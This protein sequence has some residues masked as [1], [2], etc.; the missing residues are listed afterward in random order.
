MPHCRCGR[1]HR[2]SS[3]GEILFLRAKGLRW[4]C[5]AF[6]VF[7]HENTAGR[8]R[9]GVIVGKAN[10]NAVHRNRTKRILREVV[11]RNKSIN[12]PFFDILIK[13]FHKVL[14]SPEEL[15]SSYLRWKH[16]ARG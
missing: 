14:P 16:S 12:P 7:F 6:A 5:N 4:Q 15:R 8:D 11:R 1:E 3:R 2:I 9:F 10:G 13:P